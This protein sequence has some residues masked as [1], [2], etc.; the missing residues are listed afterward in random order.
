MMI[1][2]SRSEWNG[3]I[4][5]GK[6]PGDHCISRRKRNPFIQPMQTR[7]CSSSSKRFSFLNQ[8]AGGWCSRPNGATRRRRRAGSLRGATS[9]RF[10]TVDSNVLRSGCWSADRGRWPVARRRP[11][12]GRRRVS[13]A[14]GRVRRAVGNGQVVGDARSPR[15][16]RPAASTGSAM[17]RCENESSPTAMARSCL[18]IERRH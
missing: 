1:G 17:V 10:W 4:S 9:S 14:V 11:G 18:G 5:R 6:N 2:Y 8:P 12:V 15:I 3:S 13:G 7:P 16:R